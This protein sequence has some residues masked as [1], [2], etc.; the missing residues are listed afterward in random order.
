MFDPHSAF[1]QNPD[2][3][4]RSGESIIDNNLRSDSD[5]HGRWFSDFDSHH[6]WFPDNQPNKFVLP[7]QVKEDTDS[8]AVSAILS[9]PT[10]LTS[11]WTG[12]VGG[13]KVSCFRLEGLQ[14]VYANHIN[15]FSHYCF[16]STLPTVSQSAVLVSL[17]S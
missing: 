10:V 9:S 8:A 12:S 6:R 16:L 7:K 5:T 14:Q 2:D 4:K 3:A 13:C 17:L 15:E 11:T 1:D